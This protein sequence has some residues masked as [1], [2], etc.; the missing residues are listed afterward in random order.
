MNFIIGRI[1][2][3]VDVVDA[4]MGHTFVTKR[5]QLKFISVSEPSAAS[6]ND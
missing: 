2:I 6:N 1:V 5:I 4:T 3:V